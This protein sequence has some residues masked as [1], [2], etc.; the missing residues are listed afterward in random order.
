MK[1][2]GPCNESILKSIRDNEGIP[3][4][5]LRKLYQGMVQRI[6]D[7]DLKR[8]VLSCRVK[9]VDGCYWTIGD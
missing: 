5:D 4:E 7:E 1:V 6:F 8:L 3:Y 2:V 9:E